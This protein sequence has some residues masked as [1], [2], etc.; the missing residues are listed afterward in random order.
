MTS[1]LNH[2]QTTAFFAENDYFG[3]YSDQITF[4]Q[5]DSL[6]IL[7]TSGEVMLTSPTTILEGPDGNGGVFMS[8]FN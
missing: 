2:S 4:F 1:D 8:L 6:P 3:L 5:Q 7:S